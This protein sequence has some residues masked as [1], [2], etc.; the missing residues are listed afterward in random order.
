MMGPHREAQAALF[1][2]F[3]LEDHV[4]DDQNASGWLLHGNSLRAPPL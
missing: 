2:E 1:Y 3:C 4:P